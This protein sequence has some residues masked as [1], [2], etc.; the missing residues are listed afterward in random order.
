MGAAI[1][2]ISALLGL[3]KPNPQADE[4]RNLRV[5]KR[6]YKQLKKEFK[7]GGLDEEEKAM[8]KELKKSIFK[9]TLELS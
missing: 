8:L 4:R 5:A 3:L 9:R 6:T 1:P 7:K 2:L